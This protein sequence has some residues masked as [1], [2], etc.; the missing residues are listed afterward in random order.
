MVNTFI[1]YVHSF[2]SS[3]VFTIVVETLVLFLLLRYALKNKKPSTKKIV[4]A[5]VF[6]SF[7][8]IPYVWFVFPYIAAWPGNVLYYSE[9]FAFVAE[10]AFYRTYLKTSWKASLLVS[11]LCNFSSYVLGYVLHA[12]G[13]WF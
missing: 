7:A 8:T 11:L 12:N 2:I 13:I 9:S 5:G 1:G 4:F 10:A 3:L 6:A